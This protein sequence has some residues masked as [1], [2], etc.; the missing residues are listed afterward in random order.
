MFNQ[1]LMILPHFLWYQ[2]ESQG[3]VW[4]EQGEITQKTVHTSKYSSCLYVWKATRESDRT[5]V[6]CQSRH[7]LSVRFIVVC[8]S[9]CIYLSRQQKC[10]ENLC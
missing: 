3:I 7:S 6:G 1:L 5:Y 4:R 10:Y 2:Y 9:F 8:Q